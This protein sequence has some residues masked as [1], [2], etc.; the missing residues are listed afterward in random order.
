LLLVKL[1]DLDAHADDLAKERCARVEATLHALE[2]LLAAE[3]CYR[4]VDLALNGFDLMEIGFVPGKTL[5]R[6]LDALLDAVLEGSLPNEREA[7]LNFA[8]SYFA[9]EAL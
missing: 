5:G 7:L 9:S 4:R 1:G 3:P 6:A 8:R 2:E